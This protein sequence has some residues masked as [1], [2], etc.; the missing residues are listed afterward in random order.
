MTRATTENDMGTDLLGQFARQRQ[1]IQLAG[2]AIIAVEMCIRDRLCC[3]PR[4]ATWSF[5]RE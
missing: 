5:S 3:L 1:A 4:G 2:G